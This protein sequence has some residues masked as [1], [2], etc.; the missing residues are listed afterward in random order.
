[1]TPIQIALTVGGLALFIGIYFRRDRALF[2]LKNLIVM[3][4]AFVL[5]SKI[6]MNL[7]ANAQ[8]WVALIGGLII[9]RLL[10]PGS[11]SRYIPARERR[12]AIARYELSGRKYNSRRHDI[13][14]RVPFSRGGNS[15]ADNLRVTDRHTNRSKKDRSPWWDVLG[16]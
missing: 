14:H 10:V 11:T 12:K 4:T 15:S 1:M 16:R 13:D 8:F 3:A 2:L 7:S 5:L 9:G 6:P